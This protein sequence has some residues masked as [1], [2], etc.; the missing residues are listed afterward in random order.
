MVLVVFHLMFSLRE[1]VHYRE[2][3]YKELTITTLKDSFEGTLEALPEPLL[4]Q[5]DTRTVYSNGAFSEQLGK[6]DFSNDLEA[7]IKERLEP[8]E[9]E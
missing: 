1:E 5:T 9:E 2:A 8:L 4:V 7:F 3:F 6:E